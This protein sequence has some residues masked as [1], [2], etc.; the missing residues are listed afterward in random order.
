V[1]T[2]KYLKI[3]VERF[4]EAERAYRLKLVIVPPDLS[5]PPVVITARRFQRSAKT[6]GFDVSTKFQAILDQ[7]AR[8]G[9]VA[10]L[11]VDLLEEDAAWSRQNKQPVEGGL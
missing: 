4:P 2:Y 8:N 10:V 7:Y 1:Y 9:F 11:A 6:I 3:D 5:A